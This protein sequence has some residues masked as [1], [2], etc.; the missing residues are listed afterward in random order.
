MTNRKEEASAAAEQ[1]EKDS[2]IIEKDP[3]WYYGDRPLK[4]NPFRVL[5]KIKRTLLKGVCIPKIPPYS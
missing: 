1:I 2:V 4:G 5:L 3:K